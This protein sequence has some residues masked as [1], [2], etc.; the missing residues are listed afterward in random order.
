MFSDLHVDAESLGEDWHHVKCYRQTHSSSGDLGLI[1]YSSCCCQPNGSVIV[2][3]W[4]FFSVTGF[5]LANSKNM[6]NSPYTPKSLEVFC[7]N[8]KVLLAKHLF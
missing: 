4:V 6:V 8:A 3:G 5:K 1:F 7:F 2:E